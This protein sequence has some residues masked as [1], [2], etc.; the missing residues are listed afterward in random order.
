MSRDW[1]VMLLWCSKKVNMVADILAKEALRLIYD[2][3]VF[4]SPPQ[5]VSAALDSNIM[6]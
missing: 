2:L 3:V 1:C 5:C 4:S 6:V